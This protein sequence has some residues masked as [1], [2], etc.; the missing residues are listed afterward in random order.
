MSQI[1]YDE[2]DNYQYLVFNGP[3]HHKLNSKA[4][5]N[6]SMDIF[7]HHDILANLQV[8]HELIVLL[9]ILE[10][11]STFFWV[12]WFPNIH[13]FRCCDMP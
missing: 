12:K 10:L 6:N 7:R 3:L 2:S 4:I 9:N 13:L 1:I 8:T 5:E 11:Y